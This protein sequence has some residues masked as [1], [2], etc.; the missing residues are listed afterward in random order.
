MGP[1]KMR[2][3]DPIAFAR[4]LWP[5]VVFYREQE[6]IIYSVV[7]NDETFVPAGNMMGHWP[8]GCS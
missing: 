8:P 5:S 7:E 2:P 6:E 4:E 1:C 3:P